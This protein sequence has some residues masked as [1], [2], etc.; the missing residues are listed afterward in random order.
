MNASKDNPTKSETVVSTAM[1]ACLR[2]SDIEVPAFLALQ[3]EMHHALRA[4]HPEWITGAGDSPM[5][6]SYELRFAQLLRL[7]LGI[8]ITPRRPR[9]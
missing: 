8:D 1:R 5:C 7:S 2:A 4:Q 6:D 3:R 9:E